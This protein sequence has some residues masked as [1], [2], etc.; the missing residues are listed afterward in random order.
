MAKSHG[1]IGELFQCATVSNTDIEA[2][3]QADAA[4]PPK[5]T[6]WGPNLFPF[7]VSKVATNSGKRTQMSAI[8]RVPSQ[9]ARGDA[10]RH[11]S[12]IGEISEDSSRR[13]ESVI[14]VDVAKVIPVETLSTSPD[15]RF[16]R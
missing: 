7:L 10:D 16:K 9:D 6:A 2:P 15:G 12:R 14:P 8:D 11:S 3:R 5:P 1:T 13:A 4:I